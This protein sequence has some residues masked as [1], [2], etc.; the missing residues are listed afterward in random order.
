VRTRTGYI[1]VIRA[2]LRQHG[3]RVPTG[4]A[5]GFLRRVLALRLP[6]RL[7]STGRQQPSGTR[8][9]V[10]PYGTTSVAMMNRL[11]L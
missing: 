7:L 5:E 3:W 10:L 6:G 9:A 1:S 2:L 11:K 4:S 8:L